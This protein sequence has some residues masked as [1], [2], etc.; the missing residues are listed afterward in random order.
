MPIWQILSDLSL[1]YKGIV[2]FSVVEF[3]T[4]LTISET[5]SE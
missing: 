4:I 3:D 5:L 1:A 2:H